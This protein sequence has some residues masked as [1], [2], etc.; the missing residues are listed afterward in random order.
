MKI[1]FVLILIFVILFS[2]N[3]S[4][5]NST[6]YNLSVVVS[7]GGTNTSAGNYSQ[8]TIVGGISGNISNDNHSTSFGFLSGEGSDI[9]PPQVTINSPTLITYAS[10]TVGVDIALNEKGFCEYSL[11]EGV[12]NTSMTA[13]DSNTGFTATT[14]SLSNGE[15]NLYA[16]CNDTIGNKNYTE[17]VTFTINVPAPSVSDD[18]GGGG[19]AVP[20][21]S[22]EFSVYPESFTETMIADRVDSGF[23]IITNR[24]N[25]IMD[26]N[27]FINEFLEGIIELNKT[28]FSLSP[29]VSENLEFEITSPSEP[30]IYTGKIIVALGAEIKEVLVSINVQ[31]DTSLFDVLLSIPRAMKVIGIGDNLEVQVDLLQMG[32][33]EKMDVT[34]NYVVKDF[35]GSVYIKESETIAVY[36]QKKFSKKFFTENLPAGNY[37]VGVELIYPDGVA[38]ASSHFKIEEEFVL[39]RNDIFNVAIFLG[40][41]SGF[42]LSWFLIKR[43]KKLRGYA[44]TTKRRLK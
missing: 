15:H 9:N 24:G 10:A 12:T 23:I 31:T 29:G 14:L 41:V 11:D 13:N 40:V 16:Y 22:Y 37:V 28:I 8:V 21:I 2:M 4:S 42:V 27:A 7:G 17:N 18:G 1:N 44:K 26:F 32:L 34:L 38:V 35:D 20:T 43:Y 33:K 36:D 19:G 5:M 3:V 30:G 6:N 25:V 39:T